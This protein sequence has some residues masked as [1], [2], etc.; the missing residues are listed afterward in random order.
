MAQRQRGASR[1]CLELGHVDDRGDVGRHE[2]HQPGQCDHVGGQP[3]RQPIHN[4][5]RAGGNEI[6]PLSSRRKQSGLVAGNSHRQRGSCN[7]SSQVYPPALYWYSLRPLRAR[8]D[9][10]GFA[11]LPC[12][13]REQNPANNGPDGG[14]LQKAECYGLY[15]PGNQTGGEARGVGRS[16][17]GN[18]EYLQNLRSNRQR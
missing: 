1:T 5:C 10:Y 6:L 4:V 9:R 16:W 2:A 18:D 7:S 15:R 17:A 12:K 3:P 8:F 13:N 14:N 11:M